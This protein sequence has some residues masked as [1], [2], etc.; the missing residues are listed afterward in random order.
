MPSGLERLKQRDEQ[1]TLHSTSAPTEVLTSLLTAVEAQNASLT[2]M[3]ARQAKL[4][5]RLETMELTIA[6]QIETSERRLLSSITQASVTLPNGCSTAESM[7]RELREIGLTLQSLAGAID[8]RQIQASV[9]AL[10]SATTRIGQM[11]ARNAEQALEYEKRYRSA[12]NL[13]GR[14]I[15]TT[16]DQ[17]I[18]AITAS[19]SSAA[20]RATAQA[21]L[22]LQQVRDATAS[23]H[24][25]VEVAERLQ[26]PLAWAAAARLALTLLPVA[27]TLLMAVMTIWTLVVGVRWALTQHWA[28]WLN[29]AAG[30]GLTGLVAGSLFGF[31]RLVVRVKQALDEAA[32]RTGRGKR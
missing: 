1:Q 20:E 26:K 15:N 7:T 19:A 23:A 28:L 12:L 10:T 4:A 5:S 16:R 21:S 3:A 32:R 31:W 22:G 17:A 2:A 13:A 11:T 29:I 6:T 25:L 27:V 18:E 30:L 9:S 24:Q 14:A 8:G